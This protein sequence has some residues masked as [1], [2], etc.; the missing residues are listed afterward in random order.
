MSEI[1][2][3]I[4]DKVLQLGSFN[5]ELRQVAEL[6][7]QRHKELEDLTFKL[8]GV[9]K[10]IDDSDK[11]LQNFKNRSLNEEVKRKKQIEVLESTLQLKQ[12]EFTQL[13]KLELESVEQIKKEKRALNSEIGKL[14]EMGIEFSVLQKKLSK[15]N[16]K[17]KEFDG[18]VININRLSARHSNWANKVLELK[19][20]MFELKDS[21]D[22]EK[23]SHRIWLKETKERADFELSSSIEKM[24]NLDKQRRD[25]KVVAKRLKKIWEQN[26]L[27]PFPK[28]YDA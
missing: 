17:K 13:M 2:R 22:A 23:K 21:L 26:S 1:D 28:I 14:E 11:E 9:K 4:A 20:E 25:L 24:D 10:E 5:N 7:N 8:D 15:L 12:E 16:E 27:S 18:L 3:K 19:N 6:T